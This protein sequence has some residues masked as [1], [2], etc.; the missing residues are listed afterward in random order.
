MKINNYVDVAGHIREFTPGQVHT[1][2]RSAY[3]IAELSRKAG[4]E[5]AVKRELEFLQEFIEDA[6][7]LPVN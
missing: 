2:I 5:H 1:I 3:A 4:H 6:P 7:I